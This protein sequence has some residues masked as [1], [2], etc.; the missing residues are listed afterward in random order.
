MITKKM[1]VVLIVIAIILASI[2]V[3]TLMTPNNNKI[4]TDAPAPEVVS[5]S[6][7]GQVGVIITPPA[8]EDKTLNP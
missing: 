5:S 7:A 2:S 8:I 3:Y 6:G 4:S 1:V